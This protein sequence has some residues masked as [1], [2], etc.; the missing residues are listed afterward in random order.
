MSFTV[1]APLRVGEIAECLSCL[2]QCPVL[3][4]LVSTLEG[5]FSLP[6]TAAV[7]VSLPKHTIGP[8][9][10][11]IEVRLPLCRECTARIGSELSRRARRARRA[12]K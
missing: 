8:F 5:A 12:C 2:H 7:S 1:E 11:P 6:K 10:I 4:E 9:S 3:C